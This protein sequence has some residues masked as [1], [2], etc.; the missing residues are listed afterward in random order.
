MFSTQQR[1]FRPGFAILVF[2]HAIHNSANFDLHVVIFD[3]EA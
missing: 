3:H 2:D 1:D